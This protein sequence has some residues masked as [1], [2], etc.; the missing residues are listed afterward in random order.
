MGSKPEA[1][2]V[3]A[4]I[5]ETRGTG[6]FRY[7]TPVPLEASPGQLPDPNGDYIIRVILSSAPPK[8]YSTRF[9]R[10]ACGDSSDREI[11][12]SVDVVIPNEDNAVALEL[13][14]TGQV[15][16]KFDPGPEP[17]EPT[18]I[19][20]AVVAMGSS[21]FA[22]SIGSPSARPKIEWAAPAPS[23]QSPGGVSP[24]PGP[25]F[26][27]QVS[28]DDGVTWRTVGTGLAAPEVTLDPQLFVGKVTVRVRVIASNGF[29]TK[30]TVQVLSVKDLFG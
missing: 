10:D 2:H 6:S 21:P 27:V 13:V 25:F 5:N 24:G 9:R 19:R 12:G 3:V 14:H 29:T 20:P 22:N 30:S 7:V 15:L 4:K 26:T 11:T 23:G 18:N 16:D 8:E 28:T 17:V 1:I